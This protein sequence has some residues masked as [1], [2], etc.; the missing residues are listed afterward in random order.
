M[1]DPKLFDFAATLKYETENAFRVTGGVQN[2][3]RPKKITEDNGDGTFTILEWL[4]IEK[5][6]V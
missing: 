2:Y 5:G 1:T 6:I 3:R 4:A